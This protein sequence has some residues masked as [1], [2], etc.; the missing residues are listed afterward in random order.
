MVKVESRVQID[1][2]L[3]T[4]FGYLAQPQKWPEWLDGI[5]DASLEGAE[6]LS[7]GSRVRLIIKFLGRRFEATGQVIEYRQDDRI[8]MQVLSGPFPM[9]WR[10]RVEEVDG[11]TIL[12]T[13]LEG[14]PGSFF[15]IAGPLLK[16]VLQRHFDDDHATLKALMELRAPIAR[17]FP[18]SPSSDRRYRWPKTT[19]LEDQP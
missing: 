12:T 13:T 4:V 6:S 3:A 7:Q 19:R 15:A 17:D 16:P 18:D 1:R 2:S 5:L 14:E 9:S 11:R 8:G 10:Y